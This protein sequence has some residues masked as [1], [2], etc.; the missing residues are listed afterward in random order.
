MAIGVGNTVQKLDLVVKRLGSM[1]APKAW[2]GQSVA[3]ICKSCS[4]FKE[5]IFKVYIHEA[6]CKRNMD[7][8]GQIINLC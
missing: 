6:C 1:G 5:A 4:K 7:T 8:T 3:T 2:V